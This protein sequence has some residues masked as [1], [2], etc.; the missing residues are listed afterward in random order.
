M[1]YRIPASLSA[2][3]RKQGGVISRDQA[4]RAGM[5][6]A[7]IDG[8]LRRGRWQA[9]YPAVYATFSGPVPRHARLHAAVLAAG[10]GAVLSHLTA[11][12][13]Y[14]LVDAAGAKVH[15]TIPH[16]RRIARIPG[17][18]IHRSGRLDAARHPTRTPPVTRLVDTV[19]DLSDRSTTLDAACGW[20]AT[21]CSRGLTTPDRLR[22]RLASRGRTRWRQELSRV[23]GDLDR[24][25][26]S[27]LEWRYL[28]DVER[29]HRLPTADRQVRQDRPGGH[30][31]DDVRYSGFG[32]VVELDGRIAHPD[33]KIERDR[34]RDN[35]AGRRGD[36]VL[37]YRWAAVISEPCRVAA[38]VGMALAIRGWTGRM[39]RCHRPECIIG[40]C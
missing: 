31:Y 5:P 21:A 17:I 16:Q 20:L 4:R 13:M 39:I 18:V 40:E 36:S 33:G 27:V 29:A 6:V 23:L 12:E 26:R 38:E 9:V 37:H 25:C 7:A 8:S 28:R 24:G 10:A 1:A 15:V 2:L 14:G 22:A 11:A 35:H 30:L 32:L 19:F 3:A 34:A